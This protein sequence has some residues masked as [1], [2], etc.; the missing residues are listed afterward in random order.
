MN[1]ESKI[2]TNL[3]TID[4]NKCDVTVERFSLFWVDNYGKI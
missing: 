4:F 2:V 1:K 3:G